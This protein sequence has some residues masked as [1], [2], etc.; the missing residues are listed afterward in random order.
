M[1]PGYRADIAVLDELESPNVVKVIK[2]GKVVAEDGNLIAILGNPVTARHKSMQIGPIGPQS[3]EIRAESGL[4]SVIG[5][6]P[7]QIITKSLQLF[8][9]VS[10]GKVV[11]DIDRDILKMAVVERHKATGNVGLGLVQ[12]FGLALRRPGHIC[13]P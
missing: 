2:D 13:R 5:V 3:F 6:V 1:L 7:S 8:P 10:E 4:A 11:S 9:K 12:G